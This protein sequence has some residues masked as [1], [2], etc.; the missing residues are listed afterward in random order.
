[1]GIRG[2]GGLRTQADRPPDELAQPG[3]RAR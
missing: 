2:R 1:V 3:V